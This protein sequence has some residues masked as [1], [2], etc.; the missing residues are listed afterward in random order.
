MHPPPQYVDPNGG[1][2][3][4]G[5]LDDIEGRGRRLVAVQAFDEGEL[6]ITDEWVIFIF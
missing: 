6:I 5:T 4:E 1:V 2:R 3:V